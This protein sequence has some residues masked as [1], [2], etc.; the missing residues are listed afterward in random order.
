MP[1][2][3]LEMIK[4]RNNSSRI[5]KSKKFLKNHSL[6]TSYL[7]CKAKDAEKII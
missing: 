2:S 5:L 3:F 6:D 7:K 4:H 1:K